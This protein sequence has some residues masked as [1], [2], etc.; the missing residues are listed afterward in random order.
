DHAQYQMPILTK[1]WFHTGAVA[2]RDTILTRFR[3][4]YWD[5]EM[6]RQGFAVIVNEP[7]LPDA[8]LVL[9]PAI[10]PNALSPVR[11]ED[12]REALRA[13]KGMVLRKEVFGLDAPTVGATSGELQRQLSPYTVATHNCMI[14]LLQ[15][16]LDGEH[17]IFV[18]KESEAVTWN[19][20]R[21]LA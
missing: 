18:V 19:Y 15:P 2:D 4:E 14:E 20:E 21:D 5:R 10:D 13:G 7:A 12:W 1:T 3:D 16:V 6:V 9:G 17:A 11:P 8:R